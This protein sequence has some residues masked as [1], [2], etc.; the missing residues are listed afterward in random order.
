MER[1]KTIE[2]FID[3]QNEEDRDMWESVFKEE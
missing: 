1:K 3:T 2:T